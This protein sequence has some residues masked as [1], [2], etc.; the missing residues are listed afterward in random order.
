MSIPE[1]EINENEEIIEDIEPGDISSLVVFSRDW[2]RLQ[3]MCD[4]G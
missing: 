4:A 2:T 3:I 1:E